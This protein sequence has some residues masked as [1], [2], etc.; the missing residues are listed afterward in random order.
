[1]GPSDSLSTQKTLSSLPGRSPSLPSFRVE[2]AAATAG[3][4]GSAF[5]SA[6]FKVRFRHCSASAPL[7]RKLMSTIGDPIF[8]FFSFFFRQCGQRVQRALAWI[9]AKRSRDPS[10]FFFSFSP[11]L[12]PCAARDRTQSSSRETLR[13]VVFSQGRPFSFP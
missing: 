5:L 10:F 8:S 1:M 7:P 13:V 2:N 11:P 4:G 12:P 9:D 6:R 3:G